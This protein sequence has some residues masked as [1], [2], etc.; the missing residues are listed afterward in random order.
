MSDSLGPSPF[1]SRRTRRT[2]VARPILRLHRFP[3]RQ[4]IV[5]P[6]RTARHRNGPC[7]SD[8]PTDRPCANGAMSRTD[9]RPQN[10]QPRAGGGGGPFARR[11][12]KALKMTEP[13]PPVVLIRG[14]GRARRGN[15]SAAKRC[16][17]KAL[18][19]V[20]MG[21]HPSHMRRG[22]GGAASGRTVIRSPAKRSP[23]P[24]HRYNGTFTDHHKGTAKLHGSKRRGNN[25]SCGSDTRRWSRGRGGG[26]GRNSGSTRGGEAERQRDC[27]GAMD[28]GRGRGRLP[29]GPRTRCA[30]VWTGG[31]GG[32]AQSPAILAGLTG[33][34][35][36]T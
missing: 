31:R 4:P 24:N 28:R 10:T 13:A 14:V 6:S 35:G 32:L 2:P 22:G 19:A 5:P 29:L 26:G 8:K 16:T 25:A 12:A 9:P 15:T 18:T 1:G 17:M 11:R 36:E 23:A 27:V 33:G 21:V 34:G 20:S 7:F 30:C 3:S